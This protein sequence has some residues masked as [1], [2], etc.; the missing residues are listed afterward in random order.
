MPYAE[1]TSTPVERSR[2]EIEKVI[3]KHG[4]HDFGYMMGRREI[5]VFFEANRRRLLFKIPMPQETEFKATRGGYRRGS[6]RTGRTAADNCAGEVRRR[7]RALLLS[8]KGKLEGV[9]NGVE[10]FDD[11]FLAQIVLPN[12]RTVGDQIRSQVADALKGG[13]SEIRLLG[14]G[15]VIDVEP[16]D[17]SLYKKE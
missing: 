5:A 10:I 2:A 4:G 6:Y 7:W 9:A 16:I 11:A 17:P 12:G 3:Y 13:T 15:E 1:G 14:C 8:L